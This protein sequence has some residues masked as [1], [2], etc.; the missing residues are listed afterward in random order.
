M[1]TL[2]AVTTKERF[3]LIDGDPYYLDIR[4]RMLHPHELSLA[5]GFPTDYQFMGN[6]TEIVKQIGNAVPCPVAHALVSAAIS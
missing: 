3:A 2:D 5:Q 1:D 4:F 6:K